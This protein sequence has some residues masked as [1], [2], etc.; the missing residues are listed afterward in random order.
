MSYAKQRSFFTRSNL[1][2][3]VLFYR[4]PKIMTVLSLFKG[5]P[6]RPPKRW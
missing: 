1:L 3:L 4:F 5:G 6:K 2:R